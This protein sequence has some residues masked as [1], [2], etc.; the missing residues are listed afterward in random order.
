[1]STILLHE[2]KH[3]CR[4]LERKWRATKLSVDQQIYRNQYSIV[5]QL[6][7]RARVDYYSENVNA[8]GN[9]SKGLFTITKHLL[10]GS[11]VSAMPTDLS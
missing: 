4:K 7:L 8:C 3:L 2:A 1:M 10:S 9:D 11:E 5:N 6:L